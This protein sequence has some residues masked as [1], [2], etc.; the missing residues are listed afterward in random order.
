[1]TRK[2]KLILNTA[3]SLIHQLI[4]VVCGIILPR[5]YIASF[6]SE[7][8]G[9]V[10]SITQFISII[11]FL[12]LGV[13]AVVQAAL[14][15]PLA[16]KET[17]E[18][19]RII[20]SS[21]RFFKKIGGILIL[22]SLV[23]FF[24]YPMLIDTTHSFFYTGSLVAILAL[25]AFAQYFFGIS[26]Q[27]LLQADQLAFVAL[28]TNTVTVII[29]TIVV[30]LLIKYEKSVQIVKLVS[31]MIFLIRPIIFQIVVKKRYRLQLSIPLHV[32][33]IKQKWNGIAQ[34][35]ASVVLNSTDIVVL[36]VFSSFSLVSVYSV[37]YL[38]VNSIKKILISFTSGF[39]ALFGNMLSNNEL[40][41]LNQAFEKFEWIMHTFVTIFFTCTGIL[42]IPFIIVYTAT[43][44]DY[45]Y[46]Y[47]VFGILLVVAHALYCIRLPYNQLV[48]AAG[49]F[50]ET[51]TS[52]IIEASINIVISIVL[53]QAYGLIGVALGTLVAMLYRT[54]YLAW[55]LS[56]NIIK[57]TL[58]HFYLHIVVDAISVVTMVCATQWITLS[59]ISF[60]AW[61]VMAL[62]VVLICSIVSFLV[63]AVFYPRLL[64]AIP[65]GIMR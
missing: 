30:L 19:S 4:T 46:V 18:I 16:K 38:V 36:T 23:L 10:A 22:Y 35:I 58:R 64:K 61:F 34:H 41:K 31:S 21:N 33:P 47:P 29:N 12:E 6:G 8:N 57:R 20:I 45:E 37:Y 62:K 39:Q 28:L 17:E 65:K 55:Y 59:S 32:E 1:M 53:V 56:K 27:L 60:F 7:V 9:L 15:F 40:S 2:Q 14:Y 26:Y 25:S 44:T 63:N 5:A 11:T 52:A 51:Q 49:H 42:I 13:G 3:S 48:L 50:K 54:V 24:L 43:I